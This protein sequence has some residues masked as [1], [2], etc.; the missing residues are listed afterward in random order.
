MLFPI[1]PVCKRVRQDGTANISIQYCYN[2]E[3]RIL[4]STGVIIPAKNWDK[5]TCCIA[6]GLPST[7]GNRE[8]L[9]H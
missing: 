1:K 3:K 7:Y 4:L 8:E 9:N 2:S 6:K 5:K